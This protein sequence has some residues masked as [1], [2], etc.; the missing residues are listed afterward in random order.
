MKILLI[1]IVMLSG[2]SMIEITH[3][4]GQLPDV[5]LVGAEKICTK[6]LKAKIKTN[7]FVVTCTIDI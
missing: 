1:A 4:Q 5:D 7:Q 2:C 6:K 3:E